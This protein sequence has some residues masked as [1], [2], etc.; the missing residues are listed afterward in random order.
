[1]PTDP[2]RHAID[3][4]V[5]ETFDEL[6]ELRRALHQCPELRYEEYE[7]SERVAEHLKETGLDLRGGFARGTGL[8]AVLPGEASDEEAPGGE[9]LACVALR[10]DLDALPI[11]E[12][13]GLPFA[14]QNPGRMHACGHDCHSAVVATAARVVARSPLLRK[15]FQGNLVFLFQPAEEGGLGAQ[16]MMDT[17]AL[18]D[19]DVEAI[20]GFHVYPALRTGELSV[21]KKYSH[22]SADCFDIFF[23]GKG[24]HAG[25]PHMSRDPVGA[26][27]EFL[28][29]T[30]NLVSREV[31][32]LVPAAVSVGKVW[33]GET[34]NVIPEKVEIAGTL[35]TTDEDTRRHLKARLQEAAESLAQAHGLRAEVHFDSGCPS[36][37]N[38]PRISQLFREEAQAFLRPATVHVP[39]PGMGSEDFG[40]YT[41]AL[42]GA[43]FRLGCTA[44]TAMS[45]YPLHNPRFVVDEESL[46]LA[47]KIL[48]R[49]AFRLLR[50][51]FADPQ[52]LL[53]AS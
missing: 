20:L 15:S 24:G 36:T 41:Q 40:F 47:T 48:L 6:V 39:P 12:D 7:T 44:P 29:F 43:L 38:D 2:I 51:G 11:Q 1:M 46:R 49:T 30:R 53:R 52:E 42:P 18:E 26:G 5:D 27:A 13:T 3:R 31:D 37:R 21:Y 50:Q 35:R 10:A 32:P 14:S 8:V 23:H 9:G 17:G 45:W 34:H 25:Y 19:P 28:L 22:A 16:A 33:A 4:G